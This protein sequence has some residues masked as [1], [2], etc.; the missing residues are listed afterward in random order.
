MDA[1]APTWKKPVNEGSQ[2]LKSLLGS[3]TYVMNVTNSDEANCPV[4]HCELKSV[5]CSE[6]YTSSDSLIQMDSVTPFYVYAKVDSAKTSGWRESFCIVCRNYKTNQA[7][8]GVEVRRP[9][10]EFVQEGTPSD[11]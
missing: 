7:E 8:M 6:P 11:D 4:E 2:S 1:A 5:D 10:I 3:A 9:G